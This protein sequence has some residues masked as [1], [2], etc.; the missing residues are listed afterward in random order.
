MITT[1]NNL[2]AAIL[3]WLNSFHST[4]FD[5]FMSLVTGKW[6]WVPMYACILVVLTL[7]VSFKPK[8]LII[9]ATI[10]LGLFFSDFFVSEYIRPLFNRPRPSQPGSGISH[11]V[12]LVDNYR[13]GSY[14][15]P[16]C[17]ASNSFMLATIIYLIFRNKALGCFLY[18]WA[19][20]MCY[21]RAYLGVHYPGD[22]LV[23]AIWGSG[24]SYMLYSL[25]NRFFNL[26]DLKD[27]KQ[28]AYINM[29]VTASFALILIISAVQVCES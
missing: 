26:S 23:G 10:G 13:G 22:L 19:I 7:R 5:H 28:T 17:H 12:H 18:A 20:I 15:F 21:S 25:A 14:G 3:L 29:A 27:A 11:L 8:L 16:Y 4:F 1:L 9:L 6:I 24:V 2:D